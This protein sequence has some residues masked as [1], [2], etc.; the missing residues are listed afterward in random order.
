[1]KGSLIYGGAYQSPTKD[2]LWSSDGKKL[3][4]DTLSP[5]NGR[6]IDLIL[7]FD[8]SSCTSATPC[9]PRIL[10]G[11][12]QP[13]ASPTPGNTAP[14][15]LD[16]FPGSRFTMSGFG[17]S[18]GQSTIIP[19]FDWDGQALFLLN[20]IFR[21]QY[22]YLYTYNFEKKQTATL[23]SPMGTACC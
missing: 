13:L 10:P 16:N 4:I 18:G 17:T 1:M 6:Q 3:A 21:Y 5:S 9:P 8:I 7:V 2:V 11:T 20:S 14:P 22:G 15:L 19:S 12:P 23:L